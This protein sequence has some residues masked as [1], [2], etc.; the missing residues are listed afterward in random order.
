MGGSQ[1]GKGLDPRISTALFNAVIKLEHRRKASLAVLHFP[2][3]QLPP[4]G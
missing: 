4:L 2:T 1:V 3:G